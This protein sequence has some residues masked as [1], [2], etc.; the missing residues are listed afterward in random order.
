MADSTQLSGRTKVAVK[1]TKPDN[2]A[3]LP[4][5][6]LK[7]PFFGRQGDEQ[8]EPAEEEKREREQ[9]RGAQNGES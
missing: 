5:G 2:Q 1:D 7:K 6:T 9:I 4:A 3:A 8:R